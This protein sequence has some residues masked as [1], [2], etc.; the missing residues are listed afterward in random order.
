ML[1]TE[2]RPES[3]ELES[4]EKKLRLLQS[5]R[6]FRMWVTFPFLIFLLF[7]LAG[8]TFNYIPSESMLPNLK[9]GD[10][11]VTMRSWVAYPFGRSPARGDV[12]VFKLSAE[13]RK[14]A[15][16]IQS[17]EWTNEEGDKMEKP[18]ILIKRVVGLPG[19]TIQMKGS[20]VYIN[21]QKLQ[22]NYSVEPLEPGSYDP[23]PF[24]DVDPLTIPPGHY[25]LLG[26]N[27]TNSEDSRFWGAL[28]REDVLGKFVRILY[29][30][31]K[32]RAGLRGAGE[33]TENP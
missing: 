20:E 1:H 12:V 17:G 32:Q 14:L 8:F 30:D 24:A 6:K 10:N 7:M 26:D 28:R 18:E 11:I 19:E 33:E 2:E 13:Q 22:E 5:R 23:L 21:G 15:E 27:R 25:F 29:H 31:E 9:P 3:S 4:S 16:A